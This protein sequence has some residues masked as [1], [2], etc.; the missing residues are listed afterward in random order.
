LVFIAGGK[1]EHGNRKQEQ[2]D[3]FHGPK[4]QKHRGY[5]LV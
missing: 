1:G 5:L 4:V 2:E 3:F